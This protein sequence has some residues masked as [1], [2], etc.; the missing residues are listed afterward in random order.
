MI[1]LIIQIPCFNEEQSLPITLRDLP[2]KIPGIDAIETLVIDDGSTDRTA[3]VARA[4]S[5]DHIVRFSQNRGLA[6]AFAS[7]LQACLG[8]NADIIVNTDADNQYVADD[9]QKLIQPILEGRAEIVIGARPISEIVHFSWTKKLLQRFGSWVV[10]IVS[11][12]D[13]PDAPSG[14]RAFSRSAAMR[15]TTTLI[16]W[17]PSSRRGKKGC[18]SPPFRCALTG[19]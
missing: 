11:G 4:H 1:K 8:N 6:K 2:A 13:I 17:K 14:F 3:E 12:T 5:V 10:R 15:I 16:H 7:G 9:I 18:P 19:I